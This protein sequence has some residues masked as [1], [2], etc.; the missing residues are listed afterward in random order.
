[1]CELIDFRSHHYLHVNVFCRQESY[2]LSL[3]IFAFPVLTNGTSIV[4]KYTARRLDNA[5]AHKYSH[6]CS[7]LHS[8]KIIYIKK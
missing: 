1:M 5:L 4:V 8:S 7:N 2:L 3:K 6:A